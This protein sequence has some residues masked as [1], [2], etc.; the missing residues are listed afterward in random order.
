ML[1]RFALAELPA[2]PWKNGGG[3]TREIACWPAGAG[4][5]AFDWRVSVAT[6]AANGPFS[7]FAGVDRT[8]M[9]LEG[10]GVRLQA[11]GFDHRL[12]TPCEP[13]TFSGDVAV[14]CTLLGG[15]STDFNVMS[16]RARGRA[17]VRVFD[18][19]TK[20]TRGEHGLLLSVH[21]QWRVGGGKLAQGQGVWW[22]DHAEAWRLVP[23]SRGA[24]LVAMHWQSV[25][26]N[27]EEI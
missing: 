4:L 14:D 15:G 2:T 18:K 25:P 22:A 13:F 7:L 24:K 21:G 1:Q 26:Q 23:A 17:G 12:D 19:A 6:I 11:E 3:S 9:L 20:L 10:N 16:R 27:S 8:I 5:D